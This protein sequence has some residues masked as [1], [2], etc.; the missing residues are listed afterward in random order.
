[1]GFGEASRRICHAQNRF[2]AAS[3]GSMAPFERGRDALSEQPA[4]QATQRTDSG[5]LPKSLLGRSRIEPFAGDEPEARPS[6]GPVPVGRGRVS[7]SR[8]P[9]IGPML[10]SG[11]WLVASE[12]FDPRSAKKRFGQIAGVGTLGGLMGGLLAERVAARSEW[13][14]CCLCSRR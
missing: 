12:R 6:I 9:A 14:P 7:I 3:I 1:V 4:H 10:G 5:N 11:F 8:F 13:P 2:N